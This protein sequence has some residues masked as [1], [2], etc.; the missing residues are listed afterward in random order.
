MHDKYLEIEFSDK[1]STAMA[2]HWFRG[3]ALLNQNLS[4]GFAPSDGD[5]L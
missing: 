1:Q 3:A 5:A 2:Y 4:H